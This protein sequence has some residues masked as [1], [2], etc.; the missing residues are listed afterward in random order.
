MALVYFK[1]GAVVTWQGH[2]FCDREQQL[3]S[4]HQSKHTF[5]VKYTIIG[6]NAGELFI[7][8]VQHLICGTQH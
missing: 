4:R 1:Y 7:R 5:T 3:I 8:R 6:G 2:H